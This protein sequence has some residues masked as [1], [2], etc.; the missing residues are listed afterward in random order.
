VELGKAVEKFIDDLENSPKAYAR[1]EQIKAEILASPLFAEQ[2]RALWS[3]IADGLQSGLNARRE[4]IAAAVGEGLQGFVHWL[5]ETPA[6][7][8]R[9]NRTI[10]LLVLRAV[11]PR[12]E[13]IGAYVTQVVRNWESAT[14]VERIE[15]QVGSDLQY[16]RI[17][18]TLV[19]GLV[20]LLIFTVSTWV[21]GG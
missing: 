2:M 1:A 13:E 7:K 9:I 16:I 15:L 18:G 11:L 20:G 14:L 12:R 19:G 3:E 5:G 21:A 6:R 17:N 4:T 10:R 8:Q